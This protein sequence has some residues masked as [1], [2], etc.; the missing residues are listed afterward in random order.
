MQLR[1]IDKTLIPTCTAGDEV[2]IGKLLST[3][4]RIWALA[5][6]LL[7]LIPPTA[8]QQ[9]T[10]RTVQDAAR[11]AVAERAFTQ[12]DPVSLV[13]EFDVNGLK[14]LVKRRSGTQTV[15]AGLFI[16]GGVRNTT[17]EKGGVENLMI[18]TAS[19]AT[20]SFPRQRMR[21]ELS[22]MGTTIGSGVNFDYSGLTMASTRANFDRSWEIFTDVALRPA[23][24][25]D[26][27]ERVR[28]RIV[29]SLRNDTDTPDSYLQVLQARVAYAGHPYLN[30]PRG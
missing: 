19:E 24:T 16:K 11:A 8:A 20:A 30:D 10:P 12:V 15:V 7:V 25:P 17:P 21:M 23:F 14:V 6:A 4:M 18:D 27:V 3:I 1:Q 13:T 2:G 29:A 28:N 26:D 9:Q 5:V 22:R